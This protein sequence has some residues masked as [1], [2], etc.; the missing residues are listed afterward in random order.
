MK[1]LGYFGIERLKDRGIK[2]LGHFR[3]WGLGYLEV[4]GFEALVIRV[5]GNL[6]IW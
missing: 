6:R 5:F 1:G 4:V 3:F 2:G